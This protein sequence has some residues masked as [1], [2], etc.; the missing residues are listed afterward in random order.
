MFSGC[1]V[2]SVHNDSFPFGWRDSVIATLALKPIRA[3]LLNNLGYARVRD[4][5]AIARLI[6]RD[7]DTEIV[8]KCGG[9]SG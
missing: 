1:N 2:A 4:I 8:G 6:E 3:V 5:A 9:V 7:L